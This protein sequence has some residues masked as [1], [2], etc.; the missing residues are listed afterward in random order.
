MSKITKINVGGVDYE[1]GGSGGGVMTEISYA[2]L[3]SLAESSGLIPG[4]KYRIIDYVTTVDSTKTYPYKSAEHPFDIVVTAV[5]DSAL[6]AN[7]KAMPHEGDEYFAACN[8]F[9]WELKYSLEPN[10]DNY[11]LVSDT[12]GKGTI[13]YMLDEFGNEANY[14]FK[15]ILWETTSAEAKF[16]KEGTTIYY[17]TFSKAAELTDA[18]PTDASLSGDAH[19]NKIVFK[20]ILGIVSEKVVLLGIA[21]SGLTQFDI[22]YNTI[23]GCAFLPVSS[24]LVVSITYNTIKGIAVSRLEISSNFR[25]NDI[26][27]GLSIESE[28]IAKAGDFEQCIV[29]GENNPL[30][31]V[32]MD[33]AS[34]R[35]RKCLIIID[36]SSTHLAEGIT[37]K[38]AVFGE[39]TN[40]FPAS[41]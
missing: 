36:S 1:I 7:A 12:N 28:S 13:Y 5:T 23:T 25:L 2:E 26:K 18:N 6:D 34:L 38:V 35:I 41:S 20:N 16:I 27:G 32:Y 31:S 9:A 37:G 3:K 17:Y 40:Y 11:S 30:S 39:Q 24:M 14:D 8:L 10:I 15:N 19:D 21:T 33:S 29:L 4:N 22:S